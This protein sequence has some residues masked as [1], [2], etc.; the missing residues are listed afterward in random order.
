VKS[1]NWPDLTD[2]LGK[3]VIGCNDFKTAGIER[4]LGWGLGK[5][6]AG[7]NLGKVTE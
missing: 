6:T 4:G 7:N 1:W 2:P 3:G 5:E